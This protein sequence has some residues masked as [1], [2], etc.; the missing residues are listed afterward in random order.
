MGDTGDTFPYMYGFGNEFESEAPGYEGSLPPLGQINPQKCANNL[1]A[2]QISGS[3]FTA[4]R[5]SNKRR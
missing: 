2:E 1:I 3:A 4:P 5:G